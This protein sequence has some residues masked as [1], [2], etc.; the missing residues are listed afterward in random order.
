[1]KDNKT[2]REALIEELLKCI[3]QLTEKE[4]GLLLRIALNMIA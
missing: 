1:M 4:I 2:E 3:G